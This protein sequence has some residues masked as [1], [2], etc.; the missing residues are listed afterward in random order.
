MVDGD[1][2]FTLSTGGV[3]ADLSVAGLLA[4]RVMER[5]VVNAVKN[6]TSLCGLKSYSDI[7]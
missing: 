1:T 2:I 4:A 7:F 5:A 3:S 6:T